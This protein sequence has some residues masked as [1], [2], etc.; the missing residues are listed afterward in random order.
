MDPA[1]AWRTRTSTL[2]LSVGV[3]MGIVNVTPDSFSDDGR[4]GEPESAV[5]HGLHLAAE[6]AGL[7]DVG[8]E[9]TRPGAEAVSVDEELARVLPVV[10]G[11]VAGGVGVSIDTSKPEVAEAALEAGAEVVNDV[12]ALRAPGMAELVVEAGC[13]VVVMHMQGEP[14]HMQENPRYEDVV[15]EVE[16]FLLDRA[17]ALQD[18]GLDPE[19]I[20]VDPGIGFGKTLEHNLALLASL[21]RL[22]AHG[23]PVVL[24]TSRKTFLG[25][26]TGIE[27]AAERDLATAVTTALGFLGGARVFRVHD[28]PS[29]RH[30]LALASAIV[31]AQ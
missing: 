6:G 28:I 2:D 1:G 10:E 11:L 18:A 29:S 24:G 13:G 8:G 14:R 12:R 7:V 27:E 26:L 20:A 3:L 4:Y 25:T 31:R 23:F 21:G 5:A 22:A 16:G 19:R 30:A 17:R 9:S 15:V